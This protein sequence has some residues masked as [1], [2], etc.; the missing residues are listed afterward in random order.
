MKG[1][2]RIERKKEVDN[3]KQEYTQLFP[4]TLNLG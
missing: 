2:R 1:I 4:T 3:E